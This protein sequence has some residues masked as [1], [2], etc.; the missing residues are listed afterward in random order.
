MR[1]NDEIK[2][3]FFLIYSKEEKYETSSGR[4]RK[5]RSDGP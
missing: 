1:V 4:V 5:K 3:F 2:M